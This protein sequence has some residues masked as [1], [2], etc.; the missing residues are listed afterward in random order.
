MDA[1]RKCCAGLDV[2]QESI[3]ACIL[4]S[5]LD[6]KPKPLIKNFGTTTPELLQLQDWL[7]EHKCTEVAMESTGVYWKSVWNILES[8][9]QLTLANPAH[10][11]N[12]PGRK[13]DIKDAQW[14]AQLHRCGLVQAS[15][16]PTQEIRDLRDRTRYRQKL[17][18]MI[19]SEK[20]RIHKLL[21]DANIKLTT[22]VSDLFGVSGRAL[23]EKLMNGEV[24]DEEQVRSLVKTKLKKKVPQL[25]DALN[26]KVRLH[27]REMIRMHM[28]TII[29]L[30]EQVTHLEKSIQ[31]LLKPY[32][33]EVE[34]LDTIPGINTDVAACIIAEIGTNMEL[35]ETEAHLA[36]WAG[37]CPGNNESAGVKKKSKS[38]KGNKHLKAML[39]Q[40]VWAINRKKDCRITAFFHRVKRRQGE[41]KAAIATAHLYLR[42]IYHILS[43]KVEYSELGTHY[44]PNKKERTLEQLKKQ[45]EKMGYAIQLE[46]VQTS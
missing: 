13:T 21:Q 40:S 11:K 44:L 12:M 43:D 15:M 38:R 41:K 29:F 28:N 30:E 27:H 18:H 31:E 9:C 23:L 24:L 36:S 42:I 6:R 16:V 17:V 32:E 4:N 46:Q 2:H 33:E 45:I 5:P 26:G 19:T 3:T 1:I 8:S 22:F 14:I 25:L 10:I 37:I 34:L 35:F 20:N 7:A 39:C